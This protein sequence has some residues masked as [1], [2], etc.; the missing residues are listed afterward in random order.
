MLM[1]AVGL[2]AQL[3]EQRLPAHRNDAVRVV[4]R[5]H[6]LSGGALEGVEALG[7]ALGRHRLLE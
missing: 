7:M 3:D 4:F 2:T 6:K 5:H 1:R